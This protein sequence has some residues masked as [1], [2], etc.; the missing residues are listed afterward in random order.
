MPAKKQSSARPELVHPVYL[1]PE[2]L[3]SFLATLEGGASMSSEVSE[4]SGET[5]KSAGE[6]GGE[7]K[8][9]SVLS[10]L[11]IS[12]SATGKYSRD[13]TR[14][15]S[16]ESKFVRQHTAASLFNRL[17]TRMQE[18]GYLHSIDPSGDL[19]GVET[20]MLIE[21][22]GEFDESPL[23]KIVDVI[24]SIWPF[25]EEETEKARKS[26]PVPKRNGKGGVPPEQR[27]LAEAARLLVDQQIEG[28]KQTL[29]MAQLVEA[30]L[31]NSPVV[32]LLLTAPKFSGI[33]TASRELLTEEVTAA[34][35]GGTF[36][37]IGK[38]SAV[39]TSESAE[40]L[41][42]RRGAMGL[43]AEAAVLPMIEAMN[44]P[45]SGIDLALPSGKLSGPV[46]QLIPLAIFV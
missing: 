11:G 37:I 1:D 13:K 35:M 42:V 15:E 2:M 21:V 8:L 5:A 34:L 18:D 25:V 45:G 28:N 10:M 29:R 3:I 40:T 22:A 24:N 20:G 43:I 23:R 31:S 26:I 14:D 4:R 39:D 9:P 30:D 6:A 38:V 17:R 33:V 32:D 46:T 19:S 16:V 7:A 36:R 44:K 27:E 12:L 41:V